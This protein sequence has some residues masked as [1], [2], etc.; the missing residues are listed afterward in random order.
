MKI[1]KRV[2]TVFMLV[3]VLSCKMAFGAGAID[4]R[5]IMR[6]RDK[7]VLDSED[8]RVIDEFV[9]KSVG[10]LLKTRDFASISRVRAI[11]LAN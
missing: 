6:V 8:F 3:F 9:S 11:I 4:T 7:G 10:T 1:R 5:N 2:F